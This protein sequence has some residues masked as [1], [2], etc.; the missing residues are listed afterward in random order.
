MLLIIT[1]KK[2]YTGF[3]LAPKSMTLCDPEL[4]NRGF[5][6][7]L[8]IFGCETHFKSELRQFQCMQIDK[9]KLHVKF[10]AM[11]IDFDV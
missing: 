8:A 1:N 11:N 10:S 2:S 7:F 4:Q 3:R 9:N 6:G 5:Y